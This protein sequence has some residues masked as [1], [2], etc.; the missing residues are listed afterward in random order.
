MLEPMTPVPIHPMRV[1]P[2]TISGMLPVDEPLILDTP[3]SGRDFCCFT[4]ISVFRFSNHFEVWHM[5]GNS[6]RHSWCCVTRLVL[7]HT[8]LCH[9]LMRGCHCW[10]AQQSERL[11]TPPKN[12]SRNKARPQHSPYDGL[13][14]RRTVRPPEQDRAVKAADHR[15]KRN[16]TVYASGRANSRAPSDVP[17]VRPLISVSG[18]EPA[19][20]PRPVFAARLA[21]AISDP[22]HGHPPVW[23]CW[24]RV[25]RD[26]PESPNVHRWSWHSL[27]HAATPLFSTLPRAVGLRVPHGTGVL[28]H[29]GRAPL[30]V[31]FRR[32]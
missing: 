32:A 17:S 7:C 29:P 23:A 31:P 30:A 22:P 18:P 3:C 8:A 12:L 19:S 15:T 26:S 13:P 16:A 10:L 1:F 27:F 20:S 2:G 6:P 9:S 11:A 4:G 14:V 25:S 24:P 28:P 21:F 5:S